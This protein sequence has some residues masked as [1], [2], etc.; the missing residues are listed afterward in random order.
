MIDEDSE[1][2]IDVLDESIEFSY[3][4]PTPSGVKALCILSFVGSALIILKD[5]YIYSAFT[6][7]DELLYEVDRVSNQ[8]VFDSL[9]Y[10]YGWAY[11][12]E[13]ITCVITVAG[14]VFIL[15][16]KKIGFPI[17]VIGTIL[18][19][20]TIIW[21]FVYVMGMGMSEWVALLIFTY[22]SVPIS[23]IIMFGTYRKYL[24]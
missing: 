16:S 19:C 18:Y 15:N 22:I 7:T 21:F 24:H 9:I 6:F 4:G 10:S 2:D 23:F 1:E 3:N 13:I 20:L 12:I 14:S 8:N 17:Y 5:L 11:V